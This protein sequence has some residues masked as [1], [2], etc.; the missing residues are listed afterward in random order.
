MAPQVL[1]CLL[2]LA[3]FSDTANAWDPAGD[4]LNPGRII[5]NVGREMDNAGR[6]LDRSRLEAQVQ[7]GAPIFE[8]WL[9]QSRNNASSGGTSSI[10]P[11]IRQQL[12]GF[13]DDNLLNRVRFKV[14]DGGVFN[15]AALSI[16]YG[17]A[18]AVT[19]VDVVVFTSA[20]KAQ[21]DSV[22]W[23]H[24]LKHVQQFRDWGV[25]DFAIRYLRSWNSVEGEAYAAEN[26]FANRPSQITQTS[27][28]HGAPN[29]ASPPPQPTIAQICATPFGLCGMAIAIPVGSQCY[30][31]TFNGPLWGVA[32]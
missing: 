20:E 11:Q 22:L 17:G 32:R 16:Q 28:M 6:Q 8:R 27:G 21:N 18:K 14:G 4:L 31:P 30:C 7:A 29:P 5:D 15:L 26:A 25:R 1:T 13:Y 12:Q 10:P 24:E 23:A 2:T 9:H 3:S 19:L